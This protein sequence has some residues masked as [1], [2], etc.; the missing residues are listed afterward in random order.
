MHRYETVAWKRATQPPSVI[1]YFID[2]QP[3]R[4]VEEIDREE[5]LAAGDEVSAIAQRWETI[6]RL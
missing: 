4:A 6:A 5:I 1:A 2:K 3:A